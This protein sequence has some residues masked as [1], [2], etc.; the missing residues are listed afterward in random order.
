[1]LRKV[2]LEWQQQIVHHHGIRVDN[3]HANLSCAPNQY[4]SMLYTTKA[5]I[6][7]ELH[8]EPWF[9]CSLSTTKIIYYAS[10]P[11]CTT[12]VCS[13]STY[14]E[15]VLLNTLL[16]RTK[17][18]RFVHVPCE[19]PKNEK[20]RGQP[21]PLTDIGPPCAPWCTMQVGGA[22]RTFSPVPLR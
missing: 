4:K 9:A 10:V 7:T 2:Q 15:K 5:Y 17:S 12:C 18:V 13:L 21:A 1:M 6:R 3:E 14:L 11:L 8:C 19:P 22:Q 16:I 20:C